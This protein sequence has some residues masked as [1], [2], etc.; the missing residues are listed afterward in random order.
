MTEERADSEMID[1]MVD[2]VET[3]FGS[4][5]VVDPVILFSALFDALGE[6]LELDETLTD[7]VGIEGKEVPVLEKVGLSVA[8]P[9]IEKRPEDEITSVLRLERVAAIV[10][11]KESTDDIVEEDVCV[12]KLVIDADIEEFIETDFTFV[13]A[14]LDDDDKEVVIDLTLLDDMRVETVVRTVILLLALGLIHELAKEE[15]VT[16]ELKDST[17]DSAAL[18]DDEREGCEVCVSRELEV[19]AELR[20]CD[21]DTR[22]D[23]DSDDVN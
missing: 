17:F 16:S 13:E 11:V 2:V 8:L 15:A 9:L 3:D 5:I 19:I 10:S 22:G 12:R 7:G 20:V 18:D 14:P 1:V 6:A 21:N 23:D 4:V